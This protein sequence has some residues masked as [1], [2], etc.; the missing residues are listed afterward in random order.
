MSDPPDEYDKY[1]D[2]DEPA[3]VIPDIEGSVDAT[4]DY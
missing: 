4:A 1:E 3:R 2:N